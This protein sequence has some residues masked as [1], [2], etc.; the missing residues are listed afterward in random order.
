MSETKKSLIGIEKIKILNKKGIKAS[1]IL[2]IGGLFSISGIFIR[3]SSGGDLWVSYPS[4]KGSDGKY[5]RYV[6]PTKEA[7]EKKT[8]EKLNA[9][10]ID[11][12]KKE[13]AKE[14]VNPATDLTLPF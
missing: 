4:Y 5:Y 7:F 6:Y 2:Q 12:Y 13:A 9:L 3:E 8:H 14:P 1:V 10:I 11:Y